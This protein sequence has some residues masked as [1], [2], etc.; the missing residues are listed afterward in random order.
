ML[1]DWTGRCKCDFRNEPFQNGRDGIPG[2]DLAGNS[3]AAA[4]AAVAV[5]VALQPGK[6]KNGNGKN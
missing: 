4:V 6:C 1:T 2:L 3:S 5:A